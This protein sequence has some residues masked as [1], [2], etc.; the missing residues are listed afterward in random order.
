[1]I[2]WKGLKMLTFYHSPNSRSTAILTLV[3]EL[4]LADK[5]A[6]EVVS[7]PRMDGSGRRDPGNPHPEGKVPCLVHDGQVITERGAILLHLTCLFPSDLA[8]AVGTA[9]WGKLAGWLTWY[10]GVMEPVLICEAA[11][12][13]HPFLTAAIRGHAEVADRLRAA[14]AQGPWLMGET[15]TVADL[16]CS[17]PYIW[18]RDLVVKDPLIEDWV[19]RCMERPAR[20]RAMAREA[21]QKLPDAA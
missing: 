7:I 17:A 12:L 13:S 5:L 14:L 10:H 16:L 21:Q 8:P 20:Q 2:N 4:G 11:G 1:M 9:G 18:F 19:S 15:Y 3:E 6:L